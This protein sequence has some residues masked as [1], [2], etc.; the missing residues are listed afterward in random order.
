METE[1]SYQMGRHELGQDLFNAMA[2]YAP[3]FGMIGTLIGLVQML[4]S[5]DDPT[6]IGPSMAVALITTL[7][8]AL[9]ANLLFIPIA[10]KLK[11]RSD[12]EV[13]YREVVLEGVSLIQSGDNPRMVAENLKVFLPP[14]L[15]EDIGEGSSGQAATE[16][17]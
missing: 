10:G 16:E 17:G 5:M 14:R 6:T 3:A 2:K 1:L 15:R 8:G 11:A 12:E 4:R 7:Y 9:F 13:M